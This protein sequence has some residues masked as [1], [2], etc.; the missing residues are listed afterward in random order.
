MEKFT[1]KRT[2]SSEAGRCMAFLVAAL[3]AGCAARSPAVHA[4]PPVAEQPAAATPAQPAASETKEAFAPIADHHIHL[5]S[6]AAAAWK[7]PPPLPEITLPD[8][9]ARVLRARNERRKDQ[10]ALEEIYTPDALYYKGGAAGWARGEKAA[11]GRVVWTISDFPYRIAPVAYSRDESSAQIGGYF[12]EGKDFSDAN[13]HGSPTQ[14]PARPQDLTERFGTSLLSLRKGTDGQ[15]RIAAEVS[16]FEQPSLVAAVTAAD[17]IKEMDAFG[18]RFGVVISNA[19]YFDSVQPEAVPDALRKIRAE[20]DWTAAQAALYPDRLAAFCSVNPTKD[21]A[22]AELERCASSGSFRGLKLHF[23]AA[24]AKL[25]DTKEVAKIRAVMAAANRHRMPMIIHVRTGND[26]GREH[27]ETF[28]RQLVAAAPDVPIQVAHLWGGE[29]YAAP[30]L[31]VFAEAVSSGDPVA[32]NLYFDV[33]G[34]AHYAGEAEVSEVV[35]R[36]R[37]IGIGRLLWGSDAPLAEAWEKFRTN[38]PLTEDEFRTIANN[39]APYLRHLR[40]RE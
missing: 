22:L 7:T 6:P 18:T 17:K 28:L 10:K 14:V 29:S 37:Q 25:G 32:K 8:D 24:Q 33:S 9:L 20:N 21:Y 3:L 40:S 4:L 5:L 26:Y 36:M 19:Y 38:I 13:R 11:A 27:A 1:E 2:Q 34:V 30:A 39:V 35:M 16:I 31:K 15:W 23:N 12:F